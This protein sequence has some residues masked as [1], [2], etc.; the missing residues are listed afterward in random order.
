MHMGLLMPY[1]NL[2]FNRACFFEQREFWE[3]HQMKLKHSGSI[4]GPVETQNQKFQTKFV[5]NPGRK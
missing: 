4:C 2:Y 5:E 3:G 1:I